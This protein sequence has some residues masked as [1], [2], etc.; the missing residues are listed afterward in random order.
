MNSNHW[1]ERKKEGRMEG[2]KKERGWKKGGETNEEL[3]YKLVIGGRIARP[4]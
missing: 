3:I 1:V 2:T 4:Q